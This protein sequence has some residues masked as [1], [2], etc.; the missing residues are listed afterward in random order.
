[1]LQGFED[2]FCGSLSTVS[3]FVV[4][5]RGLKRGDSW[6]YFWCSVI[7]AQLLLTVILGGWIWSGDRGL[8]TILA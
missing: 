5:L 4:E 3:T 2:G 6:K 8:C 1:M 7:G